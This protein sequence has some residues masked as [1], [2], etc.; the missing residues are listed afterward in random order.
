MPND[1]SVNRPV[2]KF[3]K[4]FWDTSAENQLNSQSMLQ[5]LRLNESGGLMPIC[6]VYQIEET[7]FCAS[8]TKHYLVFEYLGDT[9]KLL[10]ERW[11]KR[12]TSDGKSRVV[13]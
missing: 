13:S 8:Y 6:H 1:P 11:A 2:M 12:R 5:S 3:V 7:K 10:T 4:E 9:L